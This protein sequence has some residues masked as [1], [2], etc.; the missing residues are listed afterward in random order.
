ME[1]AVNGEISPSSLRVILSQDKYIKNYRHRLNKPSF[2]VGCYSNPRVKVGRIILSTKF[3]ETR[4]IIHAIQCTIVCMCLLNCPRIKGTYDYFDHLLLCSGCAKGSLKIWD[5]KSSRHKTTY[6]LPDGLGGVNGLVG[7]QGRCLGV[8]TTTGSIII[9]DWVNLRVAQ[10]LGD[11]TKSIVHLTLISNSNGE[12]NLL[13]TSLDKTI[14]IWRTRINKTNNTQNLPH[15]PKISG[16]KEPAPAN[17]QGTFISQGVI[18]SQ[19][20]MCKC[21]PIPHSNHILTT[22][23]SMYT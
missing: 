3:L 17:A 18:T 20:L 5:T 12:T 1:A 16:N 7:L 8:G 6:Q 10:V 11:H 23:R 4:C 2:C 19:R 9:L 15:I 14:R 13:S 21:V 22:V